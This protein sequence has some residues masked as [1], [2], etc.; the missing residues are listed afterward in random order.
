MNPVHQSHLHINSFNNK[1]NNSN[2]PWATT[3]RFIS[4]RPIL[5]SFAFGLLFWIHRS[6]FYSGDGDQL[7]RMVEAGY[8]FVKTELA[9]QAIFQ[10]VYQ[11]LKHF[12]WDGFS[13]INLVSCIAGA[14]SIW[15]LLIFNRDFVK[16]NPLW[17][18]ALFTSCGLFL[19]CPGHT[20]YYTMF[21]IMLFYYGYAGVGYLRGSFTS[22]HAALAF[23]GA[24][25]M[26]LGIMF[27]LP[28]LLLLPLLKKQWKDYTGI[29]V[30]LLLT[31]AAFF[32]KDNAEV[33][34]IEV[35][36]LSPSSNFV[37]I[38][39]DPSGEKF[40]LMF[41]LGHYIDYIYGWAV[42]SWIFWP[43]ILW[44]AALFGI[45][46]LWRPE[47][48]FLLTYTLCFT[49]FTFVWHPNLGINQDWDLFAIE[50]A[51]S[52]LLLMTYLPEMLSSRFR[53]IALAIPLI[54]STLIIYSQI[55]EEA[56]LGHRAYGSVTIELSEAVP[57]QI[58]LNGHLKKLHNPAV[59]EGAY[60]CRIRDLRNMKSHI[61][62]LHVAPDSETHF[63]FQVGPDQGKG[64][65]HKRNAVNYQN[66]RDFVENELGQ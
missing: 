48:L 9:S 43:V 8:T 20:E 2:D 11:I 41:Q 24:A 34:G 42:R 61:F 52:L 4:R 60:E 49:F 50:S 25:W 64:D 17:T 40:Y 29:G 45:R 36:G 51:P 39:E 7:T 21:L 3:G 58:N 37:P 57:N 55:M 65:A 18:L 35:L 22:R 19:F 23:S 59:R 53:R 14:F 15:V 30:G 32:F 66:W 62:Y 63:P 38:F 56:H 26:H 16:A 1:T 5:V 46:S 27:A 31:A 6:Q 54:A 12:H 28:S 13:V 10:A 47:R 44:C 33:F